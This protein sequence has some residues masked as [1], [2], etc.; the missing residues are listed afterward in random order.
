VRGG[1][2]DDAERDDRVN[3]EHALERVVGELVDRRVDRVSGVV[4]DDVELAPGVD[5]GLHER[6]RRAVLRE[7]AGVHDGLAGDLGRR[8]LRDVAVEVVDH[9]ARAVLGQQLGRRAADP[10]RRSGDDRHLVV[11]YAHQILLFEFRRRI[12]PA[13]GRT[14]ARSPRA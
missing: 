3:V 6:V 10:A 2:A 8:L 14:S 7:V 5:R 9:H 11:Q 4:D 1:G 12:L 13:R